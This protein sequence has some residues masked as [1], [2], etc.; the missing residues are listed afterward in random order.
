MPI[1]SEELR[2][3]W[4]A[5]AEFLGISERKAR[6][7][8]PELTGCGAVFFMRLGRK[9]HKNL[10]WFPSEIKKFCRLKGAKGEVI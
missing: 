8:K 2:K 6:M 4:K 3:G 9:R 10:C 7:M 1:E 5:L